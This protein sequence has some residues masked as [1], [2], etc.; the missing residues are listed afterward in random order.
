MNEHGPI[1]LEVFVEPSFQENTYLL[2]ADGRPDAWIVDPG[3]PP[4]ARQVA[5]A[6]RD[7]E[8]AARA[9][10]LTHCHVDHIAGVSELCEEFADLELLAPAG[11]EHMLPDP[12]ENLSAQ[13]GESVTTPEPARLL[14]P[15]DELTLG[16]TVWRVLD[17]G[18][19]SPAGLAFHCPE[20]GLV[21]VGDA[22][23]AG[24]I[25]RVD[26]PGS[27]GDRL[28]TNIRQSLMTLPA[29]TVIYSG[30]GPATTVERESRGNPFVIGEI[31][32]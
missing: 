22:I 12:A 25:G 2:W 14:K 4:Q 15:G 9:I 24:S 18:G 5:S 10:L 30:H 7:S 21:F 1:R 8:L 27:S 17:V 19:H 32:L 28:L 20:A 3:F 13:I 11:E 29:E 16:S 26:F 6:I 31:R 23:F